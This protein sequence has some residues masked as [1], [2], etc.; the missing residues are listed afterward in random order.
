MSFTFNWYVNCVCTNCVLSWWLQSNRKL[1]ELM[2][3]LQ[4]Y[5]IESHPL[6]TVVLPGTPCLAQ[7]SLDHLWYRAVVTGKASYY[8]SICHFTW[9][10]S[11]LLGLEGD[12][13]VVKYVDYGNSEIV[14]MM[15][16]Q[17]LQS[18]HCVLP[19]QAIC[20]TLISASPPADGWSTEVCL[21]VSCDFKYL[22]R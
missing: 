20:C 19:E 3:E 6:T 8:G 14:P 2:M 7:F 17:Q 15:G 9:W 1:E 16:L 12:R 4:G 18:K 5:A 13:C 21:F 22:F 11:W 10:L